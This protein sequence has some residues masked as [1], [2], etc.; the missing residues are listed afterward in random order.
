MGNMMQLRKNLYAGIVLAS[1]LIVTGCGSDDDSDS[2]VSNGSDIG[3]IINNE[4]KYTEYYAF[5]DVDDDYKT[6][7][8]KIKHTRTKNSSREEI[9]TVVGSSSTAYQNSIENDD[10]GLSYYA[11]NNF[12]IGVTENFDSKYYKID[13]IDN[14]TFELKIQKD[15]A[16][17]NSTYDILTYDLSGV[18]KIDNENPVGIYTDLNYFNY[19]PDTLTF[20]QGSKCY[21]LQETAQQSYYSFSDTSANNRITI[22]EWLQYK[23]RLGYEVNNVIEEKVGQN[24]SLSAIRFNENS[25]EIVAAVEF[26]GLVYEADYLQQGV[27]EFL[28]TDPKT[29]LVE[30]YQLNNTAANFFEKQITANYDKDR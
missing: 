29:E 1:T 14:D 28:H 2:F 3:P 18:G 9:S 19:F 21:V 13:F 12:F 27:K 7:W 26:N 8:G 24:N 6:A 20:P 17:I 22:E 30:C 23:R 5:T 4:F 11:G 10:N 16:V 15:N 25:G